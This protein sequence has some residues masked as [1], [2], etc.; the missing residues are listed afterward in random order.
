[1]GCGIGR[2][3][4]SLM[5]FLDPSARYEGFD[6]HPFLIAR[7]QQLITPYFPNFHF[8]HVNVYNGY[9]NP[10]GILKSY[11]FPF[12]YE[13]NSFD[14]IFLASVFTHMLP[15]DVAHYLSEIKRV[16]KPNGKCLMTAFL[17]TDE[18]RLWM[19]TNKNKLNFKH[20]S[21]ECYIISH[22]HPEM[23]VAYDCTEFF[24]HLS[25]AG[26]DVKAFY[27]GHWDGRSSPCAT[28]QDVMVVTKH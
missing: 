17:L 5:Y 9:Y 22:K 14:F 13:D 19:A 28:M 2:I 21:G 25:Q 12:P 20:K 1:V 4:Y 3:A 24:S 8:Q 26:F 18:S 23:A 27:K 15:A 7:A 16:L 10:N 11:E 6:V